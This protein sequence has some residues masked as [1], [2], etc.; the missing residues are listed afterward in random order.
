MITKLVGQE[1]DYTSVGTREQPNLEVISSLQPD[2]IIADAER[3]KG[4]YKD[5]QQIAPTIVLKAGNLPIKKIW[6][7]LKRLQRQ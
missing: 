1:M 4:I 6:I 2:L 5:L 7:H 3:H